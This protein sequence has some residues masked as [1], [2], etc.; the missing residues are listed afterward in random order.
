MYQPML[1]PMYGM[2]PDPY[3]YGGFVPPPYMGHPMYPPHGTNF[4]APPP[5]MQGIQ[6]PP[7][8]QV[9][10]DPAAAAPQPAAGP[11]AG[12]TP[13]PTVAPV[14]Q[15]QKSLASMQVNDAKADMAQPPS[16]DG[17]AAKPHPA[18]AAE[19][20]Q[21]QLAANPLQ[22]RASPPSAAQA[23]A[24]AAQPVEPPAVADQQ[25]ASALS[26]DFDFE[27]ANARFQKKPMEAEQAGQDAGKLRAIPPPQTQSFY[28]KKTG[29]FDNISSEIKE[30]NPGERTRY[31]AADE[32]ERNILTFGDEAANFRAAPRRGRGRGNRHRGS[33]G[34]NRGMN[35]PEWA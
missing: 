3:S 13:T 35:K 29:F 11:G 30:R 1:H 2:P 23:S 28:D 9:P 22:A 8:P 4:G 6:P 18:E 5:H 24:T 33:G 7:F 10:A 31:S 19:P 26:S 14:M 16:T 15:T 34:R 20:K 12:P 25:D 32:K 27:K 21:T 17:S